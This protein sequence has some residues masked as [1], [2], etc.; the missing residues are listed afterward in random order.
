MSA[1]SIQPSREGAVSMLLLASATS[2]RSKPAT[3]GA[4]KMLRRANVRN[5][6][7]ID[8]LCSMVH[9]CC[10]GDAMS[11]SAVLSS[12]G[13]IRLQIDM[14]VFL[15]RILTLRVRRDISAPGCEVVGVVKAW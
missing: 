10:L 13:A 8:T 4:L 6:S 14:G 15:L 12:T 2:S 3:S 5:T 1:M 9:T 11:T 7:A